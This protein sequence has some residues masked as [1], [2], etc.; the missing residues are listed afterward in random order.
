MAYDVIK[1]DKQDR[2]AVLTLNRPEKLNA[3]SHDLLEEF[4]DALDDVQADQDISVLVLTG[5]GRAFSSGFDIS[6]NLEHEEEAATAHW[7]STH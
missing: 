1:L 2:I 6:P 5:T 4:V 7:D 3:L